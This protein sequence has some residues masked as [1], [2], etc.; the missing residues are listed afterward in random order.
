[1]ATKPLTYKSVSTHVEDLASGRTVAPG[2]E[3][4]LT[5]EELQDPHNARLID[6][7]VV[8]VAETGDTEDKK[9]GSS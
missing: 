1:M 4:Y 3:F 7:G 9:G 6:E 8:I 5:T 2:E